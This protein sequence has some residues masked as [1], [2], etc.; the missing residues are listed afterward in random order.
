[1]SAPI[2]P[3]PPLWLQN[4]LA[5]ESWEWGHASLG[6]R[7]PA[8]PYTMRPHWYAHRKRNQWLHSRLS[9]HFDEGSTIEYMLEMI[10]ENTV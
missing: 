9:F 6:C 8:A 2:G 3:A 7:C 5:L 4:F 10:R 1:M